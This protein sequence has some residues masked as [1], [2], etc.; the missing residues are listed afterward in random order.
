MSMILEYRFARDATIDRLLAEPAAT[1]CVIGGEDAEQMYA[2]Y[3]PLPQPPPI[4]FFARLFGKQ[5]EPV[6]A[7]PPL[8]TLELVPPEGEGGDLDKAW[9]ALHF[10]LTGTDWGGDPPLCFL[11]SGGDVI[12]EVDLGYNPVRALRANDVEPWHV[13]LAPIDRAELQRRF[14]PQKM[15]DEDIYPQIWDSTPDKDDVFGYVAEYFDV[16]KS[17]VAK[18]VQNQMGMLVYVS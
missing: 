2:G 13:A 14:D 18:A 1:W 17:A 6:P 15:M 10:L 8:P 3:N 7:R 9:H 5:P 11:H 4:G 12:S 16:L